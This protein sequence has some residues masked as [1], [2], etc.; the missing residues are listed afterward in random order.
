[1]MNTAMI[2]WTCL[3]VPAFL[4]ML[5]F[6]VSVSD[7]VKNLNF[8]LFLHLNRPR[9]RKNTAS[10]TTSA[11]S[12]SRHESF[13]QHPP[14]TSSFGGPML[15]LRPLEVYLQYCLHPL[16]VVMCFFLFLISSNSAVD[17][18]FIQGE[19]TRRRNYGF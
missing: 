10:R 5:A 9:Y 14:R 2:F 7:S 18:R 19:S 8:G 11:A 17:W 15:E 12:F 6:C 13:K 3:K 16:K 4:G 1:M